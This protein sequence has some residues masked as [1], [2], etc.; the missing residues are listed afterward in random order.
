[1]VMHVYLDMQQCKDYTR[2]MNNLTQIKTPKNVHN[3]TQENEDKFHKPGCEIVHFESLCLGPM[4]IG[5]SHFVFI[6]R[7][8]I[9]TSQVLLATKKVSYVWFEYMLG[10]VLSTGSTM[11]IPK[12]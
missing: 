5:Y 8:A 6:Y 2:T 1:M 11:L 4:A 3:F 12:R 7:L 9:L 10:P